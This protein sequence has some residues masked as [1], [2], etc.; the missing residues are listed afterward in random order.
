VSILCPSEG[1]KYEKIAKQTKEYEKKKL[2]VFKQ[3]SRNY[4]ILNKLEKQRGRNPCFPATPILCPSSM[5]LSILQQTGKP[6]TLG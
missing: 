1:K 6:K 2:C 4:L 3:L 5:E